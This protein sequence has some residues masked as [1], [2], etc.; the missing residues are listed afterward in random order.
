[1]DNAHA[2][3]A[4]I[5]E[6]DISAQARALSVLRW[7]D[8]VL[9]VLCGSMALGVVSDLL[10]GN[11]QE[12]VVLV[13]DLICVAIFGF[14]AYTGWRHV[15]TIDPRV[16]RAYLL[17]FPLLFVGAAFM[18]LS[19]VVNHFS[20]DAAPTL[21]DTQLLAAVFGTS[22]VAAIALPA[23]VCVLLL[24]RMRVAPFGVTL[25]D[26]LGRLAGHQGTAGAKLAGL[27]RIK[28]RRGLLFGAAGALVIV[29]VLLAPAPSDP[30]L[31]DAAMRL[32]PQLNLLG[33]YLL[34]RARRYFQVSADSLLAVDKRSPV[35]F[36]RSFDD[37][38]KQVFADAGRALLDFS[39]ETRLANHF[40]RFG[41]FIAIGSPKDS[42]PQLGAARVLLPDDQWQ[43]R[44]LGWMRDAGLIVM[45]SGKTRWVNWELRQVIDSDR[46][47]RL[48]LLIPEI[49]G[50]RSGKRKQD[51]AARVEHI[52]EV[53]KGT[54]WSEELLAWSDFADLRAMLFRA[55]G[56]MVMVKSRSRSR[57]SYHLAALVAHQVMLE[58]VAL[59]EMPASALSAR[60]PAWRRPASSKA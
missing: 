20:D 19:V 3:A 33:F 10:V 1:M 43:E 42:V 22:W 59:P 46:A 31:A 7:S 49:K 15:G 13:F 34:L 29:G 12:S 8:Y 14:S 58:R 6:I 17:V 25:A 56:S 2:P 16:W 21:L 60:A 9:V 47:T 54:P 55:D 37:D 52:R 35:L 44:V 23:F 51:L 41:P 38:E 50:W 5:A 40:H 32:W 48:I 11:A 39:L 36:L 53:F 4:R 18:L 26:L 30:K 27:A 28:P 45:Y 57:D 24:R